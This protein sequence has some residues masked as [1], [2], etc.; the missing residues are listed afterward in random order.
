MGSD[1]AGPVDLVNS[2]MAG[3]TALDR[4]AVAMDVVQPSDDSAARR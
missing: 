2:A 1:G 4:I 3:S